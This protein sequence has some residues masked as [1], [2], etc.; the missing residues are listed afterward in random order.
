MDDAA[1]GGIRRLAAALALLAFAVMT[2][3]V[4][5]A[6]PGGERR[7][8]A[9]PNPPDGAAAR[10]SPGAMIGAWPKPARSLAGALIEKY[11]EPDRF[12]G[13]ALA[14]HDRGPWRRI[15]VFR[16][17]GPGFLWMRNKD[18][19]EQTIAYQV[20]NDRIADL[21]RFD[22]RVTVGA[23]GGELSSRAENEGMNYL[24]LNLAEEIVTGKRSVAEARDVHREVEWLVKSGKASP[25]FE[26]LLFEVRTF[27]PLAPGEDG[28]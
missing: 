14:W 12:D 26:G 6:Q 24:A 10:E 25:Y 22:K 28:R 13:S 3:V 21:G 23:S 7:V 1:A 11:G 27:R 16:D 2:A 5:S 15:V 18:L 4:P 8:P 20:P 9:A 17:A 19:L